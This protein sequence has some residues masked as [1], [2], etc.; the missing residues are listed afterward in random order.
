VVQ[1][2]VDVEMSGKLEGTQKSQTGDN[3]VHLSLGEKKRNIMIC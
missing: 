2:I 1:L 3:D